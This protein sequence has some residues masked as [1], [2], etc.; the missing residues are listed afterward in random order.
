MSLHLIL[1]LEAIPAFEDGSAK[2]GFAGLA[3]RFSLS[4]LTNRGRFLFGA[5][6]SSVDFIRPTKPKLATKNH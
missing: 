6:K 3:G 4:Y 1:S 2:S 5:G